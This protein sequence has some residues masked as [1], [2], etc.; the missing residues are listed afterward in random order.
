[1]SA[2]APSPAGRACSWWQRLFGNP[3]C[4]WL[5]YE[6]RDV[7]CG[8]RRIGIAAYQACSTCGRERRKELT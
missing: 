3:G 4:A 2:P 6:R 7:H 8:E 1:M 5:T